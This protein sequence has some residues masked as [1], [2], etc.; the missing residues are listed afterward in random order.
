MTEEST[1]TTGLLANLSGSQKLCLAIAATVSLSGAGLWGVGAATRNQSPETPASSTT[2]T[3]TPNN[4]PVFAPNSLTDDTTSRSTEREETPAGDTQS[5]AE[6]SPLE[7]Y[8]P[9]IFR[10][11]FGFFLGFAVAFALRAA[12]K[13]V[14]LV[15]GTVF[16]LLIGLQ[17]AGLISVNWDAMQAIYTNATAWLGTQTQSLT[18]FLRGYIPSGGSAVAGFAIGMLKKH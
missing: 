3:T 9:T 2:D 16:L 11:G 1:A 7:L 18:A 13:I 8:S 14:L 6:R 15:V 17:M 5:D 10:F 4:D 12:F